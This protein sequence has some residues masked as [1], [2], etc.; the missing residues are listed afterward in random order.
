MWNELALSFQN[1]NPYILLMLF[2]GFVSLVII[3]ERFIVLSYVYNINFKKF[4]DNIRKAVVADDLERARSICRSASPTS[5]PAITL[6]AIDSALNDVASTRGVIEEEALEFLPKI[7]ARLLILPG[8]ATFVLLLGVLGTVNELWVSFHSVGVLDTAKKQAVLAQGISSSLNP[9]ALGL[10]VCMIILLAHQSLKGLA[11]N[12]SE[13]VHHGLIVISNLLAPPQVATMTYAPAV[14]AMASPALAANQ[15]AST[16]T[17]S[18]N[19]QNNSSGQGDN[20]DDAAVEDIKDE[21]EII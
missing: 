20:Y 13:R 6:K 8:L 10:M 2:L 15:S 11:L 9:T 17:S 14:S 1:G 3:F 19:N 7:E 4:L 18:T 16:D 5:L 12:L 21:E